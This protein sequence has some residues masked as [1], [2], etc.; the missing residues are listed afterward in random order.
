M[1]YQFSF[2]ANFFLKC[3]FLSCK[4]HKLTSICLIIYLLS[5]YYLQFLVFEIKQHFLLISSFIQPIQ[6]NILNII[7]IPIR[8]DSIAFARDRYIYSVLKNEEEKYERYENSLI[9]FKFKRIETIFSG[10]ERDFL[11]FI[12]YFPSCC[13]NLIQIFLIYREFIYTPFIISINLLIFIFCLIS[14][15]KLRA[16]SFR[17]EEILGSKLGISLNNYRMNF[18]DGEFSSDYSAANLKDIEAYKSAM[19]AKS[20]YRIALHFPGLVLIMVYYLYPSFI[21]ELLDGKIILQLVIFSL[22]FS[23]SAF[24]FISIAGLSIGLKLFQITKKAN[25]EDQ[26]ISLERVILNGF[27]KPL[28]IKIK[29]K[30]KVVVVGNNGSGKTMFCRAITGNQSPISGKISYPKDSLLMDSENYLL[31]SDLEKLSRFG[32]IKYKYKYL[33][34]RK[35]LSKGERSFLAT[36]VA[37][38]SNLKLLVFDETFDSITGEMLKDLKKLFKNSKK[39]LVLVSHRKDIIKWFS[40]KIVLDEVI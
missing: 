19:K 32:M 31:Q 16:E 22:N 10:L 21:C 26:N 25:P 33:L 24:S 36:L 1:L 6:D 34:N 2:G 14:W 20:I 13:I 37:L 9:L 40:R 30:E 3:F 27:R 35:S 39:I 28:S 17:R 12:Q 4:K 8:N 7:K 5:I 18:K 29:N 23:R 11:V 38:K 15:T